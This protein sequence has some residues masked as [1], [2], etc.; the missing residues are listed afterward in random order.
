MFPQQLLHLITLPD[1]TF[2]LCFA[3]TALKS[4]GTERAFRISAAIPQFLRVIQL[5]NYRKKPFDS[6]KKSARLK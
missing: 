4:I 2:K 5:C 6:E 3:F 1:V